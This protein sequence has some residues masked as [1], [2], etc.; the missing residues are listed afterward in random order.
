MPLCHLSWTRSRARDLSIF[1]GP[2]C[3]ALLAL[4]GP[5]P[6][7]LARGGPPPALLARGGPPLAQLPR[8]GPPPAEHVIAY[9]PCLRPE[10]VLFANDPAGSAKPRRRRSRTKGHRQAGSS[11]ADPRWGEAPSAPPRTNTARR[12]SRRAVARQFARA[13]ARIERSAN[14]RHGLQLVLELAAE[15]QRVLEPPQRER[16]L[17]LE[18][19]LLEHSSRLYRAYFRAGLECRCSAHE[20]SGAGVVRLSS[21][22][23]LELLAALARLLGLDG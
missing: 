22:A 18:E 3:S 5:R 9:E 21:P 15:L 12:P 10:V 16:W 19:A 8:G 20:R 23:R 1:E 13:S 6:A 7:L 11:S 2:V 17:A 14:Y 4:G